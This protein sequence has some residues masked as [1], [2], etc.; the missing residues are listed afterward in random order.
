MKRKAIL[1]GNTNGLQGVQVDLNNYKKFLMSEMGGAWL[2]GEILL[3]KNPSL[4]ILNTHIFNIKLNER[5]DF[6]FLVFTGHGGYIRKAT[7]FEINEKHETIDESKLWNIAKR[8]ITISDCCR[9][10]DIDEL[11]K[12]VRMLSDGGKTSQSQARQIYD[13]RIMEAEEQQARFYSC[14]IGE[15]SIDTGLSGGGLYT[16]NLLKAIKESK[17][18]N[19][20]TINEAHEVALRTTKIEAL[21]TDQHNQNPDSR[22][23]RCFHERQLIIA[24]NPIAR[25]IF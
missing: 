21:E 1:I 5:P 18:E 15:T 7:V 11:S 3:L 25:R 12:S 9:G 19:Y 24:I 2:E 17:V 10:I 6:V 4:I 14:S 8:Q 20:L 16:K 23:I 22:V 13:K